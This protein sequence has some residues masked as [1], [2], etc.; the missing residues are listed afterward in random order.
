MVSE[1]EALVKAIRSD[2]SSALVQRLLSAMCDCV[3]YLDTKCNIVEPCPK[4]ANLLMRPSLASA[5]IAK[6]LTEFLAPGEEPR[7]SNYLQQ[8]RLHAL[9]RGEDPSWSPAQ[10]LHLN[11]IDASG[12][13]VP[14]EVFGASIQDADGVC[15]HLVGIKEAIESASWRP[16]PSSA[17]ELDAIRPKCVG[18]G[19]DEL[20]CSNTSN[21]P[22][23]V[24]IVEDDV[25]RKW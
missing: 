25:F 7:F 18:R 24:D 3:V 2:R 16:V 6:P 20:S 13:S 21:G 12:A 4:L 8:E 10:A 17:T 11:L 1:K 23:R 22:D 19:I 9:S 14:V 15:F 5:S